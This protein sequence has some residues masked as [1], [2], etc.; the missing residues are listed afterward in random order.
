MIIFGPVPSRRLGKSLGINN[1]TAN[2]IC[3]YSC[4]YCQ[5][6]LT[7]KFS[8][9]LQE[10]YKPEVI[11]SEVRQHLAKLTPDERPDYLTFVAN[12]E[13]TLD[14]HLGESINLMKKFN[15]PLAVITNASMLSQKQVRQNLMVADWV[16]IKI[17][18]GDEVHWKKINRPFKQI[19]FQ[20]YILGLL[21]F[22]AEYS[23][24]LV[25]ETML[26]NDVNDSVD[27]L[28]QTVDLVDKVRPSVAYLSIPTRPPA[29]KT[30]FAPNVEKI[31][32]AYQIFIENGLN[33]ELILGFEGTDTGFTGNAKDDI[34]NM[35]SV[36][37]I[38][39]DTMQEILRKDK[40]E[41]ALLNTL[42]EKNYIVKLRYNSKDFYLRNFER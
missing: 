32:Y 31:N 34:I 23:G 12:G 1:I 42:L 21:Q 5:V 39:E 35:C 41:P 4:I 17:D 26:V 27:V 22:S 33:T 3:S 28:R 40:A 13:P 20:Q 11:Y 18:V 2:K 36:H 7:H 10:F 15:I 25:S 16:S 6:G 24:K 38:R 30:V 8:S 29:Q 9:Q 37:P 14:I 19:S